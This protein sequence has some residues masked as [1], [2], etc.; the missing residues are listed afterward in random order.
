MTLPGW[1]NHS[2]PK[3]PPLLARQAAL[4]HVT[5]VSLGIT[6]RERIAELTLV[7]LIIGGGLFPQAYLDSSCRA[8]GAILR[9][10]SQSTELSPDNLQTK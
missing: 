4:L 6:L 5:G 8:V 3:H 2:C 7:L 10:W 9:D 1:V